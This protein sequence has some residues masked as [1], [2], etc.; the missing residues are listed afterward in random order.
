MT[1]ILDGPNAVRAA[2]GTHLGYSDWL[3]LTQDRVDRFSEAT[4]GT[5]ALEHLALA[6]SNFFL[7]QIVDV[8]ANPQGRQF[9]TRD[10]HNVA[11]WFSN[12]GVTDADGE[13]LAADLLRSAGLS[14]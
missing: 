1:R 7:P 6:L 5:G 11:T 10:A 12:H 9:L 3:E 13:E 4:S 2:V 14:R 8:V